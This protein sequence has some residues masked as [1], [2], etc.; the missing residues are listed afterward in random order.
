MTAVAPGQPGDAARHPG[1][2]LRGRAPSGSGLTCPAPACCRRGSTAWRGRAP[3]RRDSPAEQQDAAPWDGDDA[4]PGGRDRGWP[5]RATALAGSPGA[6]RA[7]TAAGRPCT[8]PPR[9]TWGHSV[10]TA[11]LGH[12][13]PKQPGRH[14]ASPAGT[15]P[16]CGAKMPPSHQ[17]AAGLGVTWVVPTGTTVSRMGPHPATAAGRDGDRGPG[18]APLPRHSPSKTRVLRVCGDTRWWRSCDADLGP[19]WGLGAV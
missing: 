14:P 17:T 6:G 12:G 19:G 18:T 13:V 1:T 3:S 7:G 9:W 11:G 5:C 4:A 8:A 10:S 2:H 15:L 16:V